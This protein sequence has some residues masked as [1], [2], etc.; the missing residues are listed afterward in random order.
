M[1]LS[2]DGYGQDDALAFMTKEEVATMWFALLEYK[3]FV[4]TELLKK[5]AEVTKD[6]FITNGDRNIVTKIRIMN[7]GDRKEAFEEQAD[8]YESLLKTTRMLAEMSE[9]VARL[10]IT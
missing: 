9:P 8:L 2:D 10:G 4:E 3:T 6:A 1:K 7:Y 5:Y